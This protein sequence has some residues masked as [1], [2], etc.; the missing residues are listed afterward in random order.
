MTTTESAINTR[1]H[2]LIERQIAEGKQ[3]GV[4]VA[5]YHK[6]RRVVDTWAGTMGPKDDREVGPD[7]LFLSF[8]TT[9]GVAAMAL[10]ILADKGQIDYDA[11]VTKYWPEFGQKG[12]DRI[13]V[14]QAMSHQSGLHAVRKPHSIDFVEDFDGYCEWLAAQEPAW[15]P[16]TAT[17]YHAMTYAW[18][19]G[20]IVRG[21]TG[22]HI[23]D[24]IRE[25]I[26]GPLGIADEMYVGIPDGIEERLTSLQ[27]A[28]VAQGAA[29]AFQIPADHDFFKAMPV[30]SD[31][32][33]NDM[34]LRKACVP[35]ANG[36]FTA[37]ALA[38]MYA[39]AANGGEID[40]V[41]LMS[42]ERIPLMQRVMTE[43]V[44]RV[45][46]MPMGKGIGFFLGGDRG[47]L[48]NV[49]GPRST[50]LG[51]SG[52]GGSTAFADPEMGLS[53]AVTLNKMQGTLQGEG[54]TFEICEFIREELG[55]TR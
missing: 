13:T 47:P 1:V 23:K 3:L 44:D 38:K 7:S 9:K 43:E 18:I 17:G 53:V 21:A 49:Q 12:K 16:G 2:D 32:T 5:A 15:E 45:L 39:V 51:H 19:V 35:S 20:G 28:P 25:E 55:I 29:A 22:R 26:A 4:Q 40:G 8:S 41:R 42:K 30:E 10:H 11:P 27:S 31:F 48:R 24:V 36:H 52:A 33:F 37:R 34:R 6:G 46:M 54:P 14:A 50:A